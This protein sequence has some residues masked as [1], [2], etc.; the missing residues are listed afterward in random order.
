[1]K[2]GDPIT[3]EEIMGLAGRKLDATVGECIIGLRVVDYNWPC[4]REP[5]CGCYSA[6]LC[7]ESLGTEWYTDS[8]PVYTMNDHEWPPKPFECR[9]RTVM[10]AAVWPVPF[11]STCI[12]DA[13][14]VHEQMTSDTDRLWRYSN[15]LLQ[16]LGLFSS[17]KS[18]DIAMDLLRRL[19]PE[20]ICRAALLGVDAGR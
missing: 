11:Y 16:L 5:E 6:A 2:R 8:G 19:S 14:M 20:L 4:G 1:M 7:R 13:W 10:A 9:G 15:E 18:V 12:D 17:S 3:R